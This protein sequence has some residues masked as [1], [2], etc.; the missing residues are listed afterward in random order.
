MEFLNIESGEINL[1]ISYESQNVEKI[2][3]KES[4]KMED[5][6][7]AFAQKKNVDYSSFLILYSGKELQG[8]DLKK[9]IFQIMTQIDKEQKTMN[10]LIYSKNSVPLS[11][12][13]FIKI[14]LIINSRDVIEL[15]GKKDESI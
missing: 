9:T 4:D 10:L 15:Q 8:S 7:S 12:Q 13:N 3:C 2:K 6:L 14:I 5:I 1:I 11:R